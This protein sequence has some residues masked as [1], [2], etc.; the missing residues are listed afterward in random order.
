MALQLLL[1]I[2]DKQRMIDLHVCCFRRT[3]ATWRS[4]W[5]SVPIDHVIPCRTRANI[6]YLDASVLFN[7]LD[8]IART[9][10]QIVVRLGAVRAR[11]P[12]RQRLVPHSP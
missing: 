11:L 1:S 4:Q 8:V 6:L 10:Q 3:P 7:E 9:R 12:A 5:Q 2:K